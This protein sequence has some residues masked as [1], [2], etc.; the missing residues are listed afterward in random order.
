MNAREIQISS[1]TDSTHSVLQ[2]SLGEPYETMP[3]LSALEWLQIG[4]RL[5]KIESLQLKAD[6]AAERMARIAI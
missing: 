3:P 6:I 5:S 1:E 4:G 2:P